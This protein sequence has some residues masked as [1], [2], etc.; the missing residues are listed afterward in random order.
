MNLSLSF[1]PLFATVRSAI[2]IFPQRNGDP[3]NDFRVWNAQLISYAGYAD[4][5][6]PKVV[7]GDPINVEFTQV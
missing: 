2:T 5:D 6:D 7:L 3:R 1:F 4:P